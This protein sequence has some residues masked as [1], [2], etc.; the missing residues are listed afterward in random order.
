[1]KLLKPLTLGSSKEVMYRES[2]HFNLHLKARNQGQVKLR[3]GEGC[4]SCPMSGFWVQWHQVPDGG[5]FLAFPCPCLFS[6]PR[7]LSVIKE[8]QRGQRQGCWVEHPNAPP[9]RTWACIRQSPNKYGNKG[10]NEDLLQASPSLPSWPDNS[11][12]EEQK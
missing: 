4:S 7:S 9:L 8:L 6:P 5:E 11:W 2:I 10:M 1:M 12:R 3:K